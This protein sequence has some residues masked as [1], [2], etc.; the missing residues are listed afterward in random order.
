[1][2]ERPFR[3]SVVG[4]FVNDG[5]KVLVGERSDAPGSWQLPQGG[6]DDGETPVAALRREMREELG[7][8]H[9]QVVREG[10]RKCRY[11]FPANLD[12]PVARKYRGQE[13]TWFLLRFDDG[14]SPS[15]E[16]SDGEFRDFRWEDPGKTLA[17][18][19]DW[20][21]QC[22]EEGFHT[23]GIKTS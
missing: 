23:I 11:D 18:I 9:F 19:I 20:K 13:Q 6:V 16:S 7:V 10:S 1:M 21:R 4:V 22:Y 8:E 2:T 15:L 3:Q 12:A 14:A 5:G 17:G